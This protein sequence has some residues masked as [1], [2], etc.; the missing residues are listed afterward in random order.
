MHYSFMVAI[1]FESIK[2]GFQRREVETGRKLKNLAPWLEQELMHVHRHA[3][4]LN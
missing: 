3:R 1:N 2:R 4:D